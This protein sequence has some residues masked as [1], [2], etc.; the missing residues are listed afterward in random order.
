MSTRKD[1][2]LGRL[3]LVLFLLL[4]FLEIATF[5]WIGGQIGILATLA[6]IIIA[7]GLGIVIIR[8]QGI[9]LLM[10]SRQMLQR[11]EIPTRQFFDGMLLAFAGL[12]FILPGFLSDLVGFLLLL[13]PV[14]GLIFNAL[15][16]NMVVVTT[17]R[18]TDSS[19]APK[20]IDLDPND[21][22]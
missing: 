15:S 19:G 12:L 6:S 13:P 14:R 21:Y 20:S 2:H 17:Y 10:D 9:G 3:I 1:D 18:P 7:A 16:K 22:R 8:W 4:P 5:I 11:G